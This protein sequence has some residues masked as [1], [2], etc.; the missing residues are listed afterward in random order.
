MRV[1]VRLDL[2]PAPE[3]GVGVVP[4]H[5]VHLRLALAILDAQKRVANLLL[6]KVSEQGALVRAVDKCDEL[7]TAEKQRK[8]GK[9][10]V[11][12]VAAARLQNPEWP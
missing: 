3:A 12:P 8:L 9:Y 6:A 11:N 7:L 1:N 5:L 2:R 4:E 10:K